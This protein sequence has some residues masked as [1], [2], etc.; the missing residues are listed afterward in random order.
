MYYDYSR[1]KGERIVIIRKM[2]AGSQF[3]N[4]NE[5]QN[6]TSSNSSA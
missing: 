1:K 2:K 4:A 5:Q 6:Q 3:T